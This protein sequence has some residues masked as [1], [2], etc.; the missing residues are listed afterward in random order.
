MNK[1]AVMKSD[2]L[3]RLE[4]NGRVEERSR[5]NC[6]EIPQTSLTDGQSTDLLRC[7]ETTENN[8]SIKYRRYGSRLGGVKVRHKRQVLQDMARPLKHWLYKHRD[9]P[10][11]T[12]TEKVLLALGSHMT[13][14]QVSN[15]FANA[16]RRLK[17]TVRQPDLSW[18]LRIK[19]YNKYIQGNAERLSV[20]SDDTDS[21][22]ECPLQNPISQS[23]FGRSSSHKSVLQKQGSVLAMAD[24]ANSDDSTSPPSKYKSSL[25]NRYLN[26]TLRHM[27]AAKADGVTAARKRRSHSESFS[28]NECERDVVSPASSYETEANFV[29][30]MDTMDYTSTKSD[31]DQQQDRGQQRQGDQAWREI[32]AAVALTSLAQGQSCTAGQ[33]G[34]AAPGTATS[35][36]CTREPLTVMRTTI[37]DRMCVKGSTCA[38]GQSCT[39]GPTIID[40]MCMKGSAPVLRQSCTMGPTLTSRIIQKSSHISEVQTVKVALANSV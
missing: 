1:V 21:D 27:M 18:A 25:L 32:H 15:W 10:Y 4:D 37:I 20:C 22:D 33:S 35:Q 40:R 29:Y 2:T 38:Q 28:S 19:L 14:V 36:G 5:L 9:N 13:L 3:L 30:H 12:K 39:V 11:P 8:T 7:Q 34:I 26:D 17:N 16:R 23:D 31:S 6:V 24:S